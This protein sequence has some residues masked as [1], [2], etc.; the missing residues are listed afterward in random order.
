MAI[1]DPHFMKDVWLIVI[2]WLNATNA[3]QSV[4]VHVACASD[5]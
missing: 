1:F 5:W 2:Q 3:F 4:S